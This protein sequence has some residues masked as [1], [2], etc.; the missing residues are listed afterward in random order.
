LTETNELISRLKE[1]KQLT[2][3]ILGE[4]DETIQALS[5]ILD[6]LTERLSEFEGAKERPEGS[7]NLGVSD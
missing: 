6:K 1:Q 4:K 7:P 3:S 5:K 2:D